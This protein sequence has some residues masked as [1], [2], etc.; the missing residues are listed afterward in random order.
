M[1]FN[2]QL[3][4]EQIQVLSDGLDELKFRIAKPVADAIQAQINEQIAAAQ[5]AQAAQAEKARLAA[6]AAADAAA[7]PQVLPAPLPDEEERAVE[8]IPIEPLAA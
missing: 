4:V 2:I 5:A 6:Q 7:A 8:R 3:T 1:I